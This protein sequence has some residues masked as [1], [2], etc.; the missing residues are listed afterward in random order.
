MRAT[1]VE[2][3]PMEHPTTGGAGRANS[4]SPIPGFGYLGETLPYVAPNPAYLQVNDDGSSIGGVAWNTSSSNCQVYVA[5]WS[6]TSISLVINAPIDASNLYQPLLVLSPL[7]DFSPLTLF[8]NANNTQS[9]PVGK[10]DTLTFTVTNPQYSPNNYSMNV[11]VG[12]AGVAPV[13][14]PT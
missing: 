10:G 7:S 3:V 13:P 12:T 5:N 1:S 14:C 4:L 9:C 2:R 6:D 11:C 8:P